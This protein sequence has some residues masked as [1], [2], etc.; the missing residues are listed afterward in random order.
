M[1]RQ[2]AFSTVIGFM[3]YSGPTSLR[4]GADAYLPTFERVDLAQLRTVWEGL[5][6][7]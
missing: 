3:A 1:A 5:P 4:V 2:R 7:P 6:R